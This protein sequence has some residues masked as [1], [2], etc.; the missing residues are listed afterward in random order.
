MVGV[1]V[2]TVAPGVLA[3]CFPCCRLWLLTRT[4]GAPRA[5]SVFLLLV[6]LLGRCCTRMHA[7]VQGRTTVRNLRKEQAAA[8]KV[9]RKVRQSLAKKEAAARRKCFRC[10]QKIQAIVRGIIARCAAG[11]ELAACTMQAARAHLSGTFIICQLSGFWHFSAI[12]TTFAS[13][14]KHVVTWGGGG[15]VYAL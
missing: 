14:C 13:M 5:I 15:Y 8:T 4:R 9:Q 12:S 7:S 11:P 10:A 6:V 2:G 1:D 3:S